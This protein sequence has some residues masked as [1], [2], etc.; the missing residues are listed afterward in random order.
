MVCTDFCKDS[1][2]YSDDYEVDGFATTDV[3][4][5]E[6]DELS[7][8]ED[9]ESCSSSGTNVWIGC[10]YR[11][12][13]KSLIYANGFHSVMAFIVSGNSLVMNHYSF[14]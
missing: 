7:D 5:Y 10:F 4:E 6:V 3:L 2:D 13:L 1:S 8:S 11:Y 12:Y 9:L 14:I